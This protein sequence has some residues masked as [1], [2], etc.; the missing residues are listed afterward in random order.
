MA[1]KTIAERSMPTKVLLDTDIDILGDIDDALCLSYLLAQPTCELVGI[2]TVSY[3]PVQR[4]RVASA[5][6]QAAGKSVPILAGASVP[7]LAALPVV[8]PGDNG[9]DEEVALRRWP[10]QQSFPRGQAIEFMRQTIHDH[11]GEIV[12]LAIGPL[13]NVALLFAVDPETPAL[14]KSLVLMGGLFAQDAGRAEWNAAFDPHATAMVYHAPV[15]IHRSIG[16][17]VTAGITLDAVEFR[18]RLQAPTDHPLWDWVEVWFRHRPSVTFHDPLAAA[19]LFDDRIC[20][21]A[22]GVVEVELADPRR[23]GVTTWRPDGDAHQVALEADRE[24]FLAHYFDVL[25]G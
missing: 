1:A 15:K 19:T 9:N 2:T 12:L 21:F 10:H 17:D 16:L 5:L 8:T 25:R 20:D 22:A 11:P 13:T 23:Q 7:L 6:C 24:R 4:A 18:A 14:L 3:A